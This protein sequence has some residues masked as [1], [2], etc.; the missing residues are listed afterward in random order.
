[1]RDIGYPDHPNHQIMSIHPLF[2]YLQTIPPGYVVSYAT[3]GR[4]FDIHPRTV[5]SILRANTLQDVYPCYRVVHADG[6]LGGYNL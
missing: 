5:A 3:L 4:V 2:F 1:M 6:T